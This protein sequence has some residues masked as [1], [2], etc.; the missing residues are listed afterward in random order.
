MGM[1]LAYVV[2]VVI[3]MAIVVVVVLLGRTP[4]PS[5]LDFLGRGIL[6]FDRV[7]WCERVVPFVI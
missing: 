3:V 2:A 6:D 4:S 1:G 5:C 7:V